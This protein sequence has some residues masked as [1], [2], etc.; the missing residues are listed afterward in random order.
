MPAHLRELLASFVAGA[1][2]VKVYI[3]GPMTGYPEYNYPAFNKAALQLEYHGYT[4]LNPAVGSG[5]Y[6]E[7]SGLQPW[8]WYMRYAIRM[9]LEADGIALL[10]GWEKSSGALLEVRIA[11]DLT[12][13]VRELS[14]W[15]KEQF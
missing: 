14:D 1:L 4:P 8:A 5:Q 10:P 6:N 2:M 15:F 12:L 9:V 11:E 7:S 13:S 3:A